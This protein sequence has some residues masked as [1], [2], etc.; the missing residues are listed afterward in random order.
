MTDVDL[1]PGAP[2]SQPLVRSLAREAT[3]TN[4]VVVELERLIVDSHLETGARL[5]SEREL[6]AQFGVSRT[7]VRE[8]VRALSTKGLVAVENG[9]GTLVQAPSA[10]SAA[11]SM[12]LFLRMQPGGFDYEKVVEV[13]RV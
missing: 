8:A 7:V 4:R 11:E 9:R 3:L 5:P 10:T 6:A 1:A 2:G 12:R 13:R